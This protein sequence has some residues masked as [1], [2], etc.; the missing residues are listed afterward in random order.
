VSHVLPDS[1]A[2]YLESPEFR[3]QS[4]AIHRSQREAVRRVAEQEEFK[5]PHLVS[6]PLGQRG[7]WRIERLV[8][9]QEAAWRE[10]MRALLNPHRP[11]RA[12]QLGTYTALVHETRGVVMS[13]T[14]AEID[15]HRPVLVKLEDP[16]VRRVLI[17]GLG[18]GMVLQHALRQPHVEHVDVVEID[19]DVRY[20]VGLHYQE[21]RL[22]LPHR[23]GLVI[24]RGDALTYKVRHGA[25]WDVAWHDIWDEI[26]SD[27]LP[28]MARLK[29]RYASR[30]GWQ[31]CWSEPLAREQR[32]RGR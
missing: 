8:I 31:G 17:S 14:P 7:P 2:E 11:D 25:R 6:V 26:S 5:S 22:Q 1:L 27:N 21:M 13:D 18:L 23:P 10:Q 12:V 30:V 32:R 9:D 3:E 29:R 15:D 4:R 28:E 16:T 20:L 24:H 19:N